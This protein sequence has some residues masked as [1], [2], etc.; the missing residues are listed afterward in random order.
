MPPTSYEVRSAC[1]PIPKCISATTRCREGSHHSPWS[2]ALGWERVGRVTI[3]SCG[4]YHSVQTTCLQTRDD[5]TPLWVARTIEG[6]DR[7]GAWHAAAAQPGGC[8]R[9]LWQGPPASSAVLLAPLSVQ[10]AGSHSH[11]R[12]LIRAGTVR[13]TCFHPLPLGSHCTVASAHP[14]PLV[15]KGGRGVR[16]AGPVAQG[17]QQAGSSR[18][19]YSSVCVKPPRRKGYR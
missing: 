11:T 18:K 13:E 9:S 4:G 6:G 1:F 10:A 2:L 15:R 17:A 5:L 8:L 12:C 7:Y 19:F 14:A 16:R 3:P